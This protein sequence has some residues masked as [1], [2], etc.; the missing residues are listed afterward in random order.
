MADS[1]DFSS[2]LVK[3]RIWP[4]DLGMRGQATGMHDEIIAA[5]SVI[6]RIP[7]VTRDRKIRKSKVVPVA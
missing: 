6:H 4:I 2:A 7:L 5:T 3:I 1:V